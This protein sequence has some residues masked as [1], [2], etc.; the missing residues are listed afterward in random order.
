MKFVRAV[1]AVMLSVSTGA[2]AHP[3]HDDEPQQTIKLNASSSASGVVVYL[4]DKGAKVPTAGA[5]GKLVW[6]S[7]AAKGEAPLQPTRD[8]AMEA[9]GAKP[10]AGSRL[11][12]SITFAD[13]SVFIG[14]VAVK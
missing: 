8:N 1:L 5:T 12:A 2:F 10:P 9:K 4:T 13:K 7:S 11:Q 14:D 6:F 3:D